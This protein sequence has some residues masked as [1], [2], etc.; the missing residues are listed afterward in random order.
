MHD[1]LKKFLENFNTDSCIYY[2]EPMSRH[3]SL[4]I[5]GPADAFVIPRSKEVL[6]SII[7]NAKKENIPVQLI[8]GG[9]NLLVGDKGIRGIVLSTLGLSSLRLM[10]NSSLYAEAGV[11]VIQLCRY[12][13]KHSLSKLE[14][15]AGLPGSLGGAV[16]MNARCYGMEFADILSKVEYFLVKD[17]SFHSLTVNKS[18]WAYKKTPFMPGGCLEGAIVLSAE[19]ILK[20]GDPAGIAKEMAGHEA[21]RRQKGHFDY[22]SAGSLFKNNHSFGRPSGAILDE[23]GF[24][25]KRIGDAMVNP[26]HANIFVNAGAASALDMLALIEE[27][28]EAAR[29]A[30][31][32]E[33]EPEVVF[34]GEF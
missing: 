32:F 16:Y 10:D 3:T 17:L 20:T 18:D 25:G 21:D 13:Q 15:A 28:R 8:G 4:E 11:E 1:T 12:A 33:L 5:G 14:F 9:A 19:L 31:G 23:L 22:P 6:I 30:Y 7:S 2:D 27:A 29:T 34:L 26:K 24:K